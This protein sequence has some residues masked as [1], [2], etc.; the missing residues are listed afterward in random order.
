M[1]PMAKEERISGVDEKSTVEDALVHLARLSLSGRE[2][3]VALY[4]QRLARKMRATNPAVADELIAVLRDTPTRSSPLRRET[5]VA[6]PVDTDSRLELVRVRIRQRDLH[7]EGTKA[8]RRRESDAS[9]GARND[10]DATSIESRMM[11]HGALLPQV[12]GFFRG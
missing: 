5:A 2:Q 10:G 9:R 11:S 8:A 1:P 6:V 3:D 4:M 12:A 7:A